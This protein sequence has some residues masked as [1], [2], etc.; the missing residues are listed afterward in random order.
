MITRLYGALIITLSLMTAP[1]LAQPALADPPPSVIFL[2]DSVTAGYGYLGQSE[3]AP[4]VTSSTNSPF[5]N[6]WYFGANSLSDC[7]PVQPVPDDRCSNNNVNGAPWE[8]GAWQPGTSAPTVA[9][10]YQIAAGQAPGAATPVENWAITGSTPAQWDTG[11]P[12]NTQLQQ[13]KNT[14]VV[15]TL[16]A[17]PI[18]GSMLQIKLSGATITAGACSN[19]MWQ[20]WNGWWAYP[21]STVV[22]CANQQ[23]VQNQ[24]SQHLQSIYQTLLTN[25]NKVLVLQY[26]RGCPWS[27]GNWQPEGNLLKGPAAGKSCTSQTQKVKACPSCSPAGSTSQWAQ[28]VAAQNAINDNIAAAVGEAQQWADDNG[29]DPSDL[30]IATPDQNAWTQHQASSDDPWVFANDTW[31]HPSIEGHEQLAQT[32]STA[33]CDAYGQWCGDSPTWTTSPPVATAVVSQ[34]LKSLPQQ[35]KNRTYVDLPNMTKQGNAVGWDSKTPRLCRI[36]HGGM[37]TT[38]RDGNCKLVAEAVR[39]GAERAMKQRHTVRVR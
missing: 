25:N 7:E 18:L 34:Q 24:Q 38:G 29:L 16:G 36:Y 22:D 4:D 9:Y 15:M 28:A 1:T 39:S 31:I 37:T 21:N 6:A 30:Q 33:M 19:T 35:V 10:S 11:G 23:W 20:A 26:Y 27:F 14:S 8:A 12:F 32:V 13:I 17:N 2:G 5:A 3:N